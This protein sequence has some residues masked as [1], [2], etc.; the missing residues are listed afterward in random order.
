MATINIFLSIGNIDAVE[1]KDF[2]L[3][4]PQQLRI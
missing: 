3:A 2:W 4:S 1:L